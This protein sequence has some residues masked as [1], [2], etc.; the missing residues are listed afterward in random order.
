MSLEY[1]NIRINK[2]KTKEGQGTNHSNR[3]TQ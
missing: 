1:A 2:T 3:K